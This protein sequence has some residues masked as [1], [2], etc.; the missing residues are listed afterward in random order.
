MR[1]AV[2][3]PIKSFTLAK[4]RL[5]DTLTPDERMN[6]A[7]RCASTVV[8]AAADMDVYVVCSD[9][10]V[11]AWA[12]SMN[13]NVVECVVP[14]LD[15]AVETGIARAV[16]DGAEH[17]IIAHS[18]LPLV[19]DLSIVV[20]RHS[21]S[22]APDRHRDGTNVMA[23]PATFPMTTAYGPGSFD[24]HL[25]IASALGLPV[26]IIEDPTLELDLDTADDLE[27]LD[28]RNKEKQ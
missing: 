24:N 12:Q 8:R 2:V 26:E 5:A 18:D 10:D 16:A 15:T 14:G 25:R 20:R 28:R 17:L 13:A 27:E 11:A 4:G 7:R 1:T 22:I 9:P 3:I 23:F 19:K 21:V 6:L